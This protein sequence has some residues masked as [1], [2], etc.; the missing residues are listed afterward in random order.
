MHIMLLSIRNYL[1]SCAKLQ[2]KAL[3]FG[4]IFIKWY[5][6]GYFEY[7]LSLWSK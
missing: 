1:Y 2:K 4:K 7:N 6:C 3:L 5:F